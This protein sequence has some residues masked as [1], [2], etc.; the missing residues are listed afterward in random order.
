MMKRAGGLIATLLQSRKALS[1]VSLATLSLVSLAAHGAPLPNSVYFSADEYETDLDTRDT[2]AKGNV[3]VRYAGRRIR[4]DEMTIQMESGKVVALRNVVYEGEGITLKGT[5]A[6][7]DMKTGTGSF[8]DAVLNYDATLNIEGRKMEYLGKDRYRLENGKL[9]FCQDCPQSWSVSGSWIEVEIEGYA[10][11]HHA[12]FQ[13]RDRPVVY[14]PVLFFPIKT[15]RQSGV[16]FPRL[17]QSTELG[18]QIAQPYFWAIDKNADAT[19]EYRYMTKGGQRLGTELRW[20]LSDRSFVRGKASYNKNHVAEKVPDDRYGFSMQQ[21]QQISPGWVQ[22]FQGEMA[23]DTLYPASFSGEFRDPKMP[24][25]VSEPSFSWQDPNFF[26]YGIGRFNRNNLIRD[27]AF[28]EATL[29]PIHT[30]ILGAE[31]PSRSLLGPFRLSSSVEQ[32]SLLR[33]LDGV[34]PESGWIRTGERST[35][36]LRLFAPLA[37]SQIATLDS[38]VELRGDAYR[39]DVEQG[40]NSAFRGRVRLDQRLGTEVG[41]VF[42]MPPEPGRK[43]KAL[44][45]S[46]EPQ[47]GW[48]WSPR[49][50]KTDHEFFSQ[51]YTFAD[52]RTLDSPKFDLFDPNPDDD[53]VQLGTAAVEQRLRPHNLLTAGFSTRLVGRFGEE[54]PTYF[55]YLEVDVAQD[56]NL[57]KGEVGRLRIGA[58]GRYAGFEASTELSVDLDTGDM[59]ARNEASFSKRPVSASVFQTVRTGKRAYGGDLK[60]APIFESWTFAAGADYDAIA[61]RFTRQS[62]KALYK[63]TSS[64]C[65]FVGLDYRRRP[66]PLDS[67]KDVVEFW[68]NVGLMV[69][70]SALEL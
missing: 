14:F 26:V 46:I 36:E 70:D 18:S 25:L 10:E 6:D 45:H 50:V 41:R 61:E 44:R 20:L 1:L 38:A 68:P 2:H 17:G 69:S 12:L 9:S 64:R 7:M 59:D 28:R 39:F 54:A 43:L 13:V 52:G 22:R 63:S 11:I 3:D 49:D 55:E 53:A 34:D 16:L 21:R 31:M 33:R 56:Y 67:T 65:W 30:G 8:T 29:G 66:N 42:A 51:R 32:L 60:L 37:L 27:Q 19:F 5:R 24:S 15:K 57:K 48:S 35:A 58:V 23:S 4:S 47:I 40:K 62:Y